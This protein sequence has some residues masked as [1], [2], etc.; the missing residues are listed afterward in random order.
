VQLDVGDPPRISRRPDVMGDL[1]RFVRQLVGLDDEP[2]I[3]G[4][5]EHGEHDE[6]HV[7]GDDPGRDPRHPPACPAPCDGSGADEPRR[8]EDVQCDDADVEVH[9]VRA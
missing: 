2:L 3:G 4:R 5:H 1:R 7:T 9:E 8:R 6:R